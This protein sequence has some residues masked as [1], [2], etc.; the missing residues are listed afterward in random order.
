MTTAGL[1]VCGDPKGVFFGVPL[2][3]GIVVRYPGGY[4]QKREL[5]L[6]WCAGGERFGNARGDIR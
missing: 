2:E 5:K 3:M 1:A 6:G 4:L